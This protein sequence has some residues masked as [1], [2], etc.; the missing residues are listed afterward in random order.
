[1]AEIAEAMIGG[2]M[3]EGCGVY[4]GEAV[5]YPQYCSEACAKMRG[6]DMSQVVGEADVEEDWEAHKKERAEKKKRNREWSVAFL[7]EHGFEVK[8][9]ND[10]NGHYRIGQWD[11]W[12]ATGV[13]YNPHT[14]IKG[15][16][17]KEFVKAMNAQ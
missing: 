16:G 5:G 6:A 2:E 1:M 17:V 7:V 11:F 12:P 8:L 10:A 14:G 3:C 4:L 15:R 9:M 13:F